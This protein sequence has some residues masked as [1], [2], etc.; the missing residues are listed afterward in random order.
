VV[1][2]AAFMRKAVTNILTT[3]PEIEVVGTAKNGQ[4]CLEQIQKLQ[5]DV[6]TLDAHMPSWT[7]LLLSAIS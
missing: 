7:A 4:E 5:P 6:I 3:D 1:D 2:D